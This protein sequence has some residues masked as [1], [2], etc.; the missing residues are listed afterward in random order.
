MLIGFLV[1][2]QGIGWATVYYYN[3]DG[4]NYSIFKSTTK[5]YARVHSIDKNTTL[6]L[7][8]FLPTLHTREKL[9]LLPKSTLA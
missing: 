9:T 1:L 5:H 4:V 8:A 3:E 7:L 6:A 2:W